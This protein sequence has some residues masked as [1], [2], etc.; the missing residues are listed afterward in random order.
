MEVMRRWGDGGDPVMEVMEVMNAWI[1]TSPQDPTAMSPDLR[2]KLT[3]FTS[4]V[5]YDSLDPIGYLDRERD[6]AYS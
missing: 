3:W 6:R 2:S 1:A 4:S 5:R